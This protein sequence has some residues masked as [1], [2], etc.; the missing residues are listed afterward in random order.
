MKRLIYIFIFLYTVSSL[1]AKDYRVSGIT[2]YNNAVKLLQP[3]DRII[4]AKGVWQDA[5]FVFYGEGTE[6][7]PI[8]LTVEEYGAT[9]IEGGSTLQLY[10]NYLVIDGLVFVNGYAPQKQV[11]EF[12]KGTEKVANNSIL[13]NCVID[14]YNKPD[15]N[16][17]D[18]W[19]NLWGRNNEV[20]NCY[21]GGKTNH[22]VTLIVW[23]NGEG[24]NKNFHRIHKNYFGARPRLGSNGGETIRIGTSH[25]SMENSNTIVESNYFEHCNGEVEILSV[26]S[27]ENRIINNTFF[28]CEGSVVLRHGHRNEV[29]GNS[30]IGNNK[31]FTGGVRIINESQRVFNNYFYGL[32]G[33]DFR[34]P[35]V[36]MNGVPN[37]V[38][39]RYHQVKDAEIMFNTW[40]DCELPWQ[41]CVGSDEERTAVPV[42]SRI[43]NN[44][45]YCPQEETLI[46]SFDR[47]NGITFANN[48]LISNKGVEKGKG[49][50]NGTVTNINNANGLPIISSN[51]KVDDQTGYITSDIDGLTRKGNKTIGAINNG[52]VNALTNIASAKNCGPSWYTP[53]SKE[54][55][56]GKVTIL[57]PGIDVLVKAVKKSNPG[58]IFE[59]QAGEYINSQ[60]I[61]I[62]HSL[63]IKA[64]N[65]S[66]RP[67]IKADMQAKVNCIFEIGGNLDFSINGL[68]INGKQ[69]DTSYVKYALATIKESIAHSY[70]MHISNCNIY[71]FE[72]KEGGAIYKAYK[73]TFADT[74]TVINSVFRDSYRGFAL[75]DEK[76][77]KGLYSAEFMI[78]DNCVFANIEQWAIDFLRGGNDEST[79]GGNLIID[80]CVF[81]NVNNR[82]NQ[83]IIKHTG[84][85]T[86]DIKNTVFFN[87]PLAKSPVRLSGRHNTIDYSAV[88][89]AGK[90]TKVNGAKEGTNII[91]FAPEYIKGTFYIPEAKSPLMGKASDG[92][93]IGLKR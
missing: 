58:D 24:H 12:K 86:I 61:V 52:T 55:V 16:S 71:N 93:N 53:I 60:K 75:N 64:A 27:C 65:T 8:T 79:L 87:S 42:N 1:V 11:I 67:V 33:K 48:L 25:V 47:T 66:E 62:P 31:P 56:K 63:T 70:N 41:L 72:N 38:A 20:V 37:S 32:K 40:V 88:Y 49:F 35:L 5:Q 90:I 6:Q 92:N 23:P 9:T 13:R 30:F 26:K 19:V 18:S 73:D 36:I 39:N 21:F 34:G 68:D 74:L 4:L 7:Q 28:E 85:I 14:S 50:I 54:K 69:G 57:S 76:D 89:Q 44:I 78:F 2:E 82:E 46:K 22:G 43:A 51:I 77:G 3:G 83:T 80:H 15:R 84:L 29:S 81:D 17:E 91:Y 10:G 45:V 59:L